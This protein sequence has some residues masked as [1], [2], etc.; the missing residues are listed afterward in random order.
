MCCGVRRPLSLEGDAAAVQF[1]NPSGWL[2]PR[3][4]LEAL[5][6][7]D[8]EPVKLSAT[9]VLPYEHLERA[10]AGLRGRLRL[11]A[12][13]DGVMPDWSTLTV[14]GPTTSLDGRGRTWFEWTGT[15]DGAA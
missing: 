5:D 2:S 14:T 9:A 1:A 8:P 12:A 10:T 13:D 4:V 15:V 3:F 6:L 11:M 7:S